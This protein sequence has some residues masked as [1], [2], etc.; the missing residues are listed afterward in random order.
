MAI[1][2][3]DDLTVDQAWDMYLRAVSETANTRSRYI[4]QIENMRK[5]HAK[6]ILAARQGEKERAIRDMLPIVDSLEKGNAEAAQYR[7][8]GTGG[9]VNNLKA[10]F[11]VVTR[12]ARSTLKG[13]SVN[14]FSTHHERFDP[15]RMEAIARQPTT[16]LEAGHVVDESKRGYTIEDRVLRPAQVKVSAPLLIGDDNG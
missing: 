3:P 10:G 13:L 9:A 12:Q 16:E 14:P 6:E 2:R 4:D 8:R 11:D 5:A 1:P 15:V 7:G